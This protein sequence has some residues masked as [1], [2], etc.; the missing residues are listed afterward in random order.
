MPS[1]LSYLSL[2]ALLFLAVDCVVVYYPWAVKSQ[3]GELSRGRL[4]FWLQ[5]IIIVT[6]FCGVL[7]SLQ[8]NRLSLHNLCYW[9]L[10]CGAG[11]LAALDLRYENERAVWRAAKFA[12]ALCIF[13]FIPLYSMIS[14]CAFRRYRAWVY[15]RDRAKRGVTRWLL[16]AV[17]LPYS[18]AFFLP[19]IG[20]ATQ[21]ESPY[22]FQAYAAAFEVLTRDHDKGDEVYGR[23]WLANP[24]FWLGVSMLISR[25]WLLA[26]L[27]AL[28][29]FVFALSPYI[30]KVEFVFSP[31]YH[32]WLGSMAV[33][34]LAA[35]FGMMH[36]NWQRRRN[37]VGGRF[38]K[39]EV[40]TNDA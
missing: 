30:N 21:N 25:D 18:I 2:I 28:I 27:S 23:L 4:Q 1:D 22:G 36:E 9:M 40:L 11:V 17:V 31:A 15:E 35:W 37:R 14:W 26:L 38:P 12:F 19:L 39:V 10:V 33:L 5:D 8:Q 34:V 7:F 13:A 6:L 24:M 32:A 20:S 3:D 16:F 29:A